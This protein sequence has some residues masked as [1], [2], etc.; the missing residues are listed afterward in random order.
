MHALAAGSARTHTLDR[1][2]DA[3]ADGLL[4]PALAAD[5][6]DAWEFLGH[7]RLRHQADLV[8]EGRAPDS[9]IATDALSSLEKQHLKAAFGVIR[10]AQGALAMRY[11]V[12]AI[13]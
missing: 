6:R 7:L 8:R 5:L 11:P 2:E 3:A 1:L 12:R 10:A 4:S 9:W 13:T